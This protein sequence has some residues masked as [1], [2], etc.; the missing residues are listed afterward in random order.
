M[1]SPWIDNRFQLT[2]LDGMY[3]ELDAMT[4]RR[5]IKSHLPLDGLPYHSWVKYIIVGRDPRDV[6]MSLYNHY[7]NYTDMAYALLDQSADEDGPFPKCPDDIHEMWRQW[8]SRGWFEWE[9]EG[10]PFWSNMHHTQSYWDFRALPN[11]MF[12]HYADMLADLD[13]CVRRISAFIGHPVDDAAVER[14]VKAT[15]F[16]K[17]KQDAIDS[18]EADPEG[19]AAFFKGGLSSFIFKG[20]NGR[21]REVLD[22]EEV[23]MYAQARQRVLS[24]DCAE[25]LERGGV[26]E[27]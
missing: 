15:S 7:S 2:P 12:L 13:A 25:W 11:F 10:Y 21:W 5:F 4:G 23:R 14:V 9:S 20:T 1:V 18:D 17:V 27:P 24:D 22:D 3:A 19:R 8:I 26:L 6:F 16:A